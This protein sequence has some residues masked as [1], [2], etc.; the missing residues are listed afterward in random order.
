MWATQ[1]KHLK[2]RD[3]G[4][5]AVIV[6][7]VKAVYFIDR[8]SSMNFETNDSLLTLKEF[9]LSQ[10]IITTFLP[11]AFVFFIESKMNRLYSFGKLHTLISHCLSAMV[12]V[13]FYI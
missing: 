3:L 7:C 9:V 12:G 5:V 10:P 11:L 6:F 2:H 1:P 13:Y 8:E 4:P